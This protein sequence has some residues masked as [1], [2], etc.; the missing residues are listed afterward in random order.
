M[1]KRWLAWSGGWLPWWGAATVLAITSILVVLD[2]SDAAVHRYWTRHSFTSSVVAGV[3]VLLL[4]VLIVD[5]VARF[6]QLKNQSRAIGAQAAVILAQAVRARDAVASAKSEDDDNQA[7]DELRTYAQMLLTSAPLLINATVP[8][9]FL[10][11]GQRV[12]GRLSRALRA[13]GDE[14]REQ[15]QARLDDG[16][17]QLRRDA[18]PLL[19]VLNL[20]QRAAV[21]SD[22]AEDH[23]ARPDA[24][25]VEPER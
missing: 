18:A 25:A 8:R 13:T 11:T 14:Q 9:T 5:R 1:L 23:P 3:L 15:A 19:A 16:I 24:D 20:Q 4:T 22:D 6:R 7:A 21:S 17:G 12:A 10:E 2:T